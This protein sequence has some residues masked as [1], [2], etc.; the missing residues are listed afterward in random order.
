MDNYKDVKTF[1]YKDV[2]FLIKACLYVIQEK[3]RRTT[4]NQVPVFTQQRIVLETRVLEHTILQSV[5]HFS[6]INAIF[7]LQY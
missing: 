2:K 7:K 1:N 6:A 5:E 3:R 4:K